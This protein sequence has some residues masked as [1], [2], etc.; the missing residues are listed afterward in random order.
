[1]RQ[2]Y[3]PPKKKNACIQLAKKHRIRK[4][5]TWL[6][7]GSSCINKSENFQYNVVPQL[8]MIGVM[9]AHVQIHSRLSQV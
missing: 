3:P 2:D 1:M 8:Y 4:K 5:S 6:K 7:M 9:W